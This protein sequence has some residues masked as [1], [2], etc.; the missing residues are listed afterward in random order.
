MRREKWT[1][2]VVGRLHICNVTSKELAKRCGY[3]APYLSMLLTGK[4][5]GT[6]E[7]K[8]W[9]F[10]NL[11]NMEQETISNKSFQQEVSNE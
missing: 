6:T 5:R 1:G 11:E 7:T 8:E 3:T 4:R 2:E 9:I 10:R